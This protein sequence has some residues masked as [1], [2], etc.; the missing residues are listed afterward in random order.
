MGAGDRRRRDGYFTAVVIGVRHTGPRATTASQYGHC[1]GLNGFSNA[2]PNCNLRRAVHV[3]FLPE[4]AG[5]RGDHGGLGDQKATGG[6]L[7][8]VSHHVRF[9]GSGESNRGAR[10]VVILTGGGDGGAAACCSAVAFFVVGLLPMVSH[11]PPR[12]LPVPPL[13]RPLLAAVVV[14]RFAICSFGGR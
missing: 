8:V 12:P 3:G 13:A 14:V 7:G 1:I 11:L 2:L 4:G 5:L 9:T 6:T 10:G